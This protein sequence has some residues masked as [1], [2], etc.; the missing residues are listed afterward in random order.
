MP[1]YAENAVPFVIAY[2]MSAAQR[3][4]WKDEHYDLV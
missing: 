3:I 2:P 4:T 1:S